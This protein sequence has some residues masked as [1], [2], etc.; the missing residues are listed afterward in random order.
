[1]SVYFMQTHLK[2]SKA[3]RFAC[4]MKI[5]EI[6]INYECVLHTCVY[7]CG[8]RKATTAKNAIKSCELYEYDILIS[9]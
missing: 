6:S 7:A 4:E 2:K 3:D 8:T 1:M 5:E 9:C